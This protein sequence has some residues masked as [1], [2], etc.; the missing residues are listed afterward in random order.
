MLTQQEL[1]FSLHLFEWNALREACIAIRNTTRNFFVS[2]ACHSVG[3]IVE[4]TLQA[5]EQPGC[6]RTALALW[7]GKDLGLRSL[8]TAFIIS[9]S[10]RIGPLDKC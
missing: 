2:C 7:Q 8:N 10:P 5:V 3:R 9:P 6:Q 4:R 1:N